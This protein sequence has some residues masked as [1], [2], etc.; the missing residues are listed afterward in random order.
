MDLRPAGVFPGGTE[1]MVTAKKSRMQTTLT[2]VRMDL[3]PGALREMYWHPPADQ[4][5]CYGEGVAREWPFSDRKRAF[6][7]KSSVPAAWAS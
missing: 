5:Q 3:Q 4:W 7:L 6:E 2:A 1:H